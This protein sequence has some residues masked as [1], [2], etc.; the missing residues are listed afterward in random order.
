M[1]GAFALGLGGS[2]SGLSSLPLSLADLVDFVSD[3]PTTSAGGYF[4]TLP[5]PSLEMG[6]NFRASA[7]SARES[8]D[9]VARIVPIRSSDF[10][11]ALRPISLSSVIFVPASLTSATSVL[12]S[13]N[14]SVFRF[15]IDRAATGMHPLWLSAAGLSPPSSR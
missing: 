7:G 15:F 3:R 6:S 2:P 4:A 11:L 13:A 9:C 8:A 12:L 14:S 10:V 5:D 1:I